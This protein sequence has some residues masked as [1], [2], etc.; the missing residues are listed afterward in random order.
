MPFVSTNQTNGQRY[1]LPQLVVVNLG[2]G[3]IKFVADSSGNGLDYLPLALERHIFR[4]PE[5]NLTNTN[6]HDLYC[7]YLN[8]IRL[9]SQAG[10]RRFAFFLY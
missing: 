8:N 5:L 4:Q 3:N 6:I 10:Q 2:Y 1:S 9:K 7:Q